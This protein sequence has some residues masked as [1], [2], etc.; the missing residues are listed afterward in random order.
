VKLDPN[1]VFWSLIY[2][3][4]LDD[5]L[6][7]ELYNAGIIEGDAFSFSEPLFSELNRNNLYSLDFCFLVSKIA[8]LGLFM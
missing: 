8:D 5:G 7:S 6:A 1:D 2:S 4:R 3:G